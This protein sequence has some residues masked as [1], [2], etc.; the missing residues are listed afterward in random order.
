MDKQENGY[1]LIADLLGFGNMISNLDQQGI[2]DLI[3]T[4][5][6]LVRTTAKTCQIKQYK[7]MSDTLFASADSSKTGLYNLILFSKMLLSKGIEKSLPIRGAISYGPFTWGDLTYGKAVVDAHILESKQN[8]IGIICD[9]PLPNIQELW[10][11]D[12][13]VCYSVPMKSGP[14][15]LYAVIDWEVPDSQ[16]F[17]QNVINRGKFTAGQNIPWEVGEKINNT[18]QYAIY[19]TLLVKYK[20]DCKIFQ[21]YFTNE[22]IRLNAEGDNIELT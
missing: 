17:I 22:L 13:L 20:A 1:M 4:W 11:I 2:D 12:S 16:S 3:E 5:V 10:G 21:G 7:L 18:L 14:M 9:A 19:R 15:K 8:W 6:D